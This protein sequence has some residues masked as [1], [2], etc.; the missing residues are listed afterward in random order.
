MAVI[1]DKQLAKF[2]AL[3]KAH[4]SEDLSP[5]DAL[6][7]AMKLLVMMKIV[8]KPITVEQYNQVQESRKQL[9]LESIPLDARKSS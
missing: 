9:G 1:T 2:K 4:F 3:Y 5:Q 7:K 8:Y 6:D